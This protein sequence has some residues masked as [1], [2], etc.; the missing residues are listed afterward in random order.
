MHP[1]AN[2]QTKPYRALWRLLTL[3]IT[4]IGTI[5][6]TTASASAL[7]PTST[8]S[9]SG[10]SVV[11]G[12]ETRVGVTTSFSKGSSARI[13]TETPA[14]IGKNQAE[15]D[16]IVSGSCV[17]TKPGASAVDDVADD[18]GGVVDDLCSFGGE[19]RVL[20]GD[21]TTKPISEIEVG[22]MVL[23]QDPETGEV[24]AR[25]VSDRWKHD[26]DL[27]RFEIDGDV[28]RTT[29][30]HPFWNDTEQEWQRA[31]QLDAGDMV[32]TADGRRVKVDVLVGSAGRGSAYNL[33]VEGL[34]TYHVLF[35]SDAVLVHNTCRFVDGQ[36]VATSD[37]LTEANRWLGSGYKD[38]G[39]GRFV[40]ADG[41]RVVRM[42]DA[43]ILGK[44]GGG[45]HMN[46]ETMVPILVVLLG[47]PRTVV[48]LESWLPR[49]LHRSNN[50]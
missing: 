48:S 16:R 21:G 26:D 33:T 17:A 28:V 50:G 47:R 14:C 8:V 23:A 24:S 34:H 7:E 43:D 49:R 20:M 22:D 4:V 6:V 5:G 39:G 31:D 11:V 15:Y 10:H 12:P 13:S 37:A 36:R 35:G 30:D 40:S 18:V 32:L 38:M 2:N 29:E 3:I 25:R 42:G 45:P 1:T 41:T 46:F 44:H 9:S 19:T 27:V